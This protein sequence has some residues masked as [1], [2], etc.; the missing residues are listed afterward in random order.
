MGSSLPPKASVDLVASY[1]R[2][3]GGDVEI[4]LADPVDILEGEMHVVLRRQ[5]EGR[6]IRCSLELVTQNGNRGVPRALLP[7]R[8]RR[9]DVGGDLSHQ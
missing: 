8:A 6:R 7:P 3:R 9:W 2:L 5:P 4:V 1:A